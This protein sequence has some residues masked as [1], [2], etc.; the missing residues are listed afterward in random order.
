MVQQIWQSTVESCKRTIQQKKNHF[1]IVQSCEANEI[2]ISDDAS[3]SSSSSLT[4][5]TTVND[6]TN[7]VDQEEHI[8][9]EDQL[10]STDSLTPVMSILVK[11]RLENIEERARRMLEFIDV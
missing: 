2:S 4:T 9:Q 5:I 11:A 8:R 3:S 1:S 10:S 7:E 6:E